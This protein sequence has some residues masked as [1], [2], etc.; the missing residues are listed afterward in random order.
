MS[1]SKKGKRNTFTK[2]ELQKNNFTESQL[3][4]FDPNLIEKDELLRL[5]FSEK[6][7]S[8][9]LNYRNKGG[10]FYKKEDFKRVYGIT[11]ANYEILKPFIVIP[12][13]E[14]KKFEKNS[15]KTSI[16]KRKILKI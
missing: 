8:T 12:K 5:G 3:F 13:K 2:R 7:T 6:V 9:I 1:I 16:K 4:E 14:F 10:K 11:E 15:K